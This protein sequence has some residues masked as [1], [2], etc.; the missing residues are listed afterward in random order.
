MKNSQFL[1]IGYLGSDA[2]L[3][4]KETLKLNN[5][6][7]S[8]SLAEDTSYITSRG[9]K[10]N[11]TKWYNCSYFM[12]FKD[13]SK[14]ANILVKG[15]QVILKGE[16]SANAWKSKEGECKADLKLNI[17]DLKLLGT[18]AKDKDQ[19]EFKGIDHKTDDNLPF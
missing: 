19:T 3:K 15:T 12:N 13:P 9:E 17:S 8:F 18:I 5:H 4:R 7:I 14:L 10:V 16:I 2:I 6:L 1:V 11:R